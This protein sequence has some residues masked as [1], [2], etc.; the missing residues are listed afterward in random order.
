M[1]TACKRHPSA[2]AAFLWLHLHCLPVWSARP[3]SQPA[4]CPPAP[5]FVRNPFHLHLQLANECNLR[6]FPMLTASRLACTA[7][8]NLAGQFCIHKNYSRKVLKHPNFLSRPVS[9]PH[10][11]HLTK[12]SP[13]SHPATCHHSQ[14]AVWAPPAAAPPPAALGPAP[15]ACPA[16][17]RCS[18]S[19]APGS[20]GGRGRS[21]RSSQWP[22]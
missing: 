13:S 6:R 21:A 22:E 10:I 11:Q 20:A 4:S 3:H 2:A 18:A 14:P 1:L 9:G 15:P 5:I 19:C 16:A 17:C 8:G 7:V 12:R